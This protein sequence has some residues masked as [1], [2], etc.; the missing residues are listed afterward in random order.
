MKTAQLRTRLLT[1]RTKLL[2]SSFWFTLCYLMLLAASSI[3]QD[4]TGKCL[5]KGGGE[6]NKEH[7]WNSNILTV[8]IPN[9]LRVLERLASWAAERA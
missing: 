6:E 4:H 1:W 2:A 9:G 8:G 3:G 5:A 7:N